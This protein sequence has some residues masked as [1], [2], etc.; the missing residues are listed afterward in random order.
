MAGLCPILPDHVIEDIFA[1][2]P[3]KFV[4]RY[5]CLSCAWAATLA[6]DDFA[7]LHLRLANRHGGPRVLLLQESSSCNNG[8]PKIQAWSPAHPDSTTLMEVPRALTREPC[9]C[10]V[11]CGISP[12][13]LVPRLL[14]QQCRGLFIIDA[15]SAETRYVFNPSTGQ[16]VALPEARYMTYSSSSLYYETLGLG[17]DT[18]TKK[19][20]VVH[21]YYRGSNNTGCE[22]YV[23]NSTGLW[24][25]AKGSAREIPPA[26]LGTPERNERLCTRTY[27]LVSQ[28]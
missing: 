22:V 13:N 9:P 14:T 16:M 19:Y 21:I 23:I 26:G 8:R 12:T 6:S 24:R 7:D 4:H 2:L 28:A 5:R 18:H 10:K 3:A 25:P 27:S 17:Y 11:T 1:R 15:V 20:K